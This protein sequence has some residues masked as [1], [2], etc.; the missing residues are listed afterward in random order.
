M[1]RGL[2]QKDK[3]TAKVSAENGSVLLPNWKIYTFHFFWMYQIINKAIFGP[4]QNLYIGQRN[5]DYGLFYHTN[6][7]LEHTKCNK[8]SSS[9]RKF[10]PPALSEATITIKEVVSFLQDIPCIYFIHGLATI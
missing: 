7:H 8:P 4:G 5:N 3:R 6:T 1:D 10:P 9:K 2:L